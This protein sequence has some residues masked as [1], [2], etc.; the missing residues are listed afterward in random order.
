MFRSLTRQITQRRSSSSEY[1]FVACKHPGQSLS[2]SS[3][4]GKAPSL[5]HNKA[6]HCSTTLT[7][8]MYIT[9]RGDWMGA[10]TCFPASP[11]LPADEFSMP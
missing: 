4:A 10:P 2:S 8:D 11:D 3:V 9:A 5:L 7:H 6:H 1:G